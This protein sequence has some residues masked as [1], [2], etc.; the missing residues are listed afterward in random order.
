[1]KIKILV[2][3]FLIVLTTNHF[4]VSAQGVVEYPEYVIREGDSLGNIAT[5]FGTT[6][7]DIIQINNIN[8]P[9]LISPGQ[10]IRIPGLQGING[11][12]EIVTTQLG[13]RYSYLPIKYNSSIENITRLNKLLLPTRVYPGSVLI[14]PT[15]QTNEP[16]VPIFSVDQTKTG[17]EYAVLSGK[18]P[19]ILNLQNQARDINFSTGGSILFSNQP[20]NTNTVDLY[21]PLLQEVNLSPLPLAQ[22]STEVVSVRSDSPVRLSGKIGD[23]E[24]AF[25]NDSPGEYFALQG[26]HALAAPGLVEFSLTAEFEDGSTHNYS[27]MVLLAPGI[28]E[29]D[30]PL[31]VDPKT[32]DPAITEPENE[33][34]RTLV[35]QKSPTRYWT[36]IFSSP[37]VYQEYNSY[38]GTRRWYNDDPQ[39]RFHTGVDYAGGL[40]LPI[41]SPAPGLV[42]FAGPLTV[43]GNAV[44]IDH[45]W[46]V[47]SGFFHQDTLNVKVGERVVTGQVIGTV[48]NTGR[49]NGAGDYFG[50]GAHLHW[51]IWVNK[52]QVNPLDWLA[53]QYP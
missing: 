5:L 10:R 34:V 49:V 38:Y 39:V 37:A 4:P 2:A 22:G 25:F 51:E 31:I 32:I 14:I 18:N 45:G 3:L 35:S 6:V 26:I 9:D 52:V 13:E 40:T 42:V 11:T 17:L 53:Y 43:R 47:F 46:G 8:N 27:Q 21:A 41:S 15:T 30:P 28:F 23:Y 48:G 1:M 16:L 44:F 33:L 24:L 36:E 12:L 7:G 50:A 20:I 19:Q 29:E